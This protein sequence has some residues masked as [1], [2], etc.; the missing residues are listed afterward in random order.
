MKNLLLSAVGSLLVSLT[1]GQTGIITKFNDLTKEG[2]MGRVKSIEVNYFVNN[3][4]RSK[5]TTRYDTKGNMTG[6]DF[7]DN[8]PGSNR[9]KINTTI[10]KTVYQYDQKGN[11][12]ERSVEEEYAPGKSTKYKFSY[13]Y[14]QN[15]LCTEMSSYKADGNPDS[16][17][18]YRYDD[19]GKILEIK[20]EGLFKNKTIMQYDA[21]GNLTEEKTYDLKN[22]LIKTETYQYNNR[23]QYTSTYTENDMYKGETVY[24]YD[25]RGNLIKEIRAGV[26]FGGELLNVKGEPYRDIYIYKYDIKGKLAEQAV[27]DSLYRLQLV[28]RYLY[29]Y[30]EKGNKTE[31]RNYDKDSNLTKKYTFQYDATGNWIQ[32]KYTSGNVVNQWVRTINYY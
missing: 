20:E 32:Q 2:L 15:D 19:K 23:G 8:T 30:D 24:S 1:Y 22:N 11:M 14:N 6:K 3:D 29:D 28:N 4:A 18:T 25:D 17:T 5:S 12:V 26:W 13:R 21:R 10:N 7:M 31:E 9:Y 16:K 27:Y